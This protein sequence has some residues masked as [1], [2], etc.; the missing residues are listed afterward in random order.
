MLLEISKSWTSEMSTLFLWIMASV[1]RQKHPV[2]L[3]LKCQYELTLKCQ[4]GYSD[5]CV[6]PSHCNN[7]GSLHSWVSSG[8]WGWCTAWQARVV[9]R[10][11][12]TMNQL[13]LHLRSS[14]ICWGRGFDSKASPST[15]PSWTPRVC[16]FRETTSCPT[17]WK[18]TSDGVTMTL[19]LIHS[20]QQ[21]GKNCHWLEES[22]VHL[23]GK[24]L[25]D[26]SMHDVVKPSDMF[27]FMH[28]Q[29][30]DMQFDIHIN[31]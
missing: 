11:C 7:L 14:F 19:K 21:Q 5:T 26:G 30:M 13:V 10:K 12:T 24:H 2:W 18:K 6:L 4:H 31:W 3:F 16:V 20:P 28:V 29:C 15:G 9:R 23:P 1:T 8:K 17:Q 22:C 27:M 25:M